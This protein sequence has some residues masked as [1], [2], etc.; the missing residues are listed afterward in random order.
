MPRNREIILIL[1][2]AALTGAAGCLST[3]IGDVR[4]DGGTLHIPV[5]NAGEPVDAVLQV[6]V[7]EV[8][9]FEQHE[10]ARDAWYI[11]LDP[12]SNEYT[13]PIDLGPGTYKLFIQIFADNDRRASVIRSLEV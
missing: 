12:G 2:V 6:A 8:S 9:M 1:I 11:V 4:Y 5:K 7:S 3:A 10:I 13:V